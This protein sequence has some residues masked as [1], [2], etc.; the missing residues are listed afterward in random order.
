MIIVDE[1][2]SS[3]QK[4]FIRIK[5]Q[6]TNE[7]TSKKKK[8]SKEEQSPVSFKETRRKLFQE[9]VYDL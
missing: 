2:I 4:I 3:H 8:A 6:Q 1:N 9:K 7:K 5:Y